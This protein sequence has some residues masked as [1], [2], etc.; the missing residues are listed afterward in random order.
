MLPATERAGSAVHW[1]V[2]HTKP[3][4]EHVACRNLLRQ[5]YRVYLPRLKVLK[6]LRRRQE[7]RF[8][9]LFPRYLFFRPAGAEHS[10]APVRSTHGVAGIVRFG[11]FPAVLGDEMLERIR[12]HEH[13]Q[14]LAD[15][16]ELSPVQPGKEVVVINGPLAGLEGLVTS[17]S[18]ERVTVLMRL[19]GEETKVRLSCREL[20]VAA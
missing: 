11:A 14:H 1:Y 10:I 6:W 2:A 17:V 15:L 4:Q 8:E 9:P 3:R 18:R 12:F 20:K 13:R 7:I 5:S 16:A 19:L